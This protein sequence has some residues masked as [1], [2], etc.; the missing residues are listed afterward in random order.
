MYTQFRLTPNLNYAGPSC[1][2]LDLNRPLS[3]PS[4]SLFK[5]LP[6]RLPPFGLQTKIIFGI[7]LLFILVTFRSQFDLYRLGFSS[8]GSAFR[9]FQNFFIPF[10]TKNGLFSCSSKK[11]L[12]D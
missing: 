4:D 8:T 6:S 9:L 1:H 2:Q 12:L 11:I 7:L 10:V 5:G 3:A